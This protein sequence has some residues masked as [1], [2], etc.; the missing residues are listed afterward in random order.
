MAIRVEDKNILA[1]MGKKKRLVRVLTMTES[2]AIAQYELVANPGQIFMPLIVDGE[3][4]EK[5]EI[6]GEQ[7]KMI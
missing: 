2:G 7:L 6:I 3:N 4:V 5:F 1:Y